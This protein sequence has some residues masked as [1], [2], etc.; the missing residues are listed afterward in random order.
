MGIDTFTPKIKIGGYIAVPGAFL[1]SEQ[2]LSLPWAQNHCY[3][4]FQTNSLSF[5]ILTDHENMGIDTTSTKIGGQIAV[6]GAFLMFEAM[7]AT[8]MG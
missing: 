3:G 7:A 8:L 2:W 6:L 1:C 4:P 5:I